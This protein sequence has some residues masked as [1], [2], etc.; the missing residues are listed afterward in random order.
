VIALYGPHGDLS[1]SK[2]KSVSVPC[3]RAVETIHLLSG[4]SGYGYPTFE[5]ED[6]TVIVRLHYADGTHEDHPLING[7][8]FADLVR[9][10][11]VPGSKIAIRNGKQQVRYL[12]IVPRRR[13]VIE[14]IE[15]VKGPS[16]ST[17]VVV[18]ITVE[19]AK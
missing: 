2:P 14:R 1:Q 5:N 11:D 15:L 13:D 10:V 9:D 17:P 18:A 12:S 8:H 6:V 4:V 7:I 3:N 16:E 19:S